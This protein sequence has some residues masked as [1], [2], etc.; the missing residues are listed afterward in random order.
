MNIQT[1]TNKIKEDSLLNN[2]TSFFDNEVYLVGGSV[3]D[4]LMDKE[5]FDRDLIVIDEDAKTFSKKVADLRV[6]SF[7]LMKKTKYIV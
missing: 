5:Y 4:A 2:I 6:Y 7:L 1:L 3:R